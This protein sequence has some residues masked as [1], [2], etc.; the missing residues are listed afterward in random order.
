MNKQ[1]WRRRYFK[2]VGTKLTAYHE[3]TRQPRATINLSN[4]KRL[5][6]DRR[7]LTDPETTGRNGKRRRSA[8]AEEEEGYM[9]VEEGFR[10]R[11]NNG[12]IIDFYADTRE[13]KTGWMKALGDVIGRAGDD[14]DG[15]GS[16]NGRRKWCDLVLKREEILRKR[17]AEL[18]RVH[19]RTKSMV[20]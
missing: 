18:R 5:I 12:E 7:Q 20:L 16:S 9:F 10:I 11:F 19:S 13:D 15:S 14:D 17:A 8:F 3:T 6:D 2:L 4:A 1:Y